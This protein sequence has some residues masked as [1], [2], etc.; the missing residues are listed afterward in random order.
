VPLLAALGLVILVLCTVPAVR[1]QQRLDREH[2][3][4]AREARQA[5]D[6]VEHLRREL[7]DSGNRRWLARKA[8]RAL[9][10]QGPRY[11]QERGP[12]AAGR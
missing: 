11:L 10:R 7:R 5:E 8:T 6:D 1:A 9:L 4:L 2:A 12:G 3:R